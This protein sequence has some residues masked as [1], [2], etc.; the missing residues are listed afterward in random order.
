MAD[1]KVV[2]KKKPG[3]KAG[4]RK[5]APKKAV[6]KKKPGKKPA[7]KKLTRAV[8]SNVIVPKIIL[9][10]WD[11]MFLDAASSYGGL[12]NA[13]THLDRAWTLGA[14]FL[15]HI[16]TTPL[17][18]STASLTVKQHMAGDLHRGLA[19]TERNLFERMRNV[20]EYLISRG[21]T[22]IHTCIDASP[23]LPED[24]LLAI[25]IISELKEEFKSRVTI[26]FGPNPIFGFK[27]DRWETF[28]EA[29]KLADF[30]SALPEKSE[31][32]VNNLSDRDGR[33]GFMQH[34]SR[35][36]RLA[37]DLKKPIQFHVDQANDPTERGAE[38]LIESL[39][40]LEYDVLE[41]FL[42]GEPKVWAVHV[43]SPSAYPE[44]RFKTLLLNLKRLNV[45]VIV[46][47]SA[48]VSM[49][50][51]RP[52]LTPTHNSIAR[53]LEMILA[54]IPIRLGSDNI[55]DVF[56]P[57]GDGDMLTESKIGAHAVR[58]HNPHLWAKLAAGT[59]LTSVDLDGVSEGLFRDREAF[60]GIAP[61]WQ[62]SIK[63]P[64]AA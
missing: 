27:D 21:T 56:V 11:A 25:R 7:A 30:L 12:F 60:K 5:P 19:Y 34:L 63:E 1:K 46:C 16:Q 8:K 35:V 2:T 55:G 59:R 51:L 22:T 31:V 41:Y 40:M 50:Q 4:K 28:V 29:A 33:I 44:D 53:M 14:E 13:H 48:A 38:R 6:A 58:S 64:L 23:D 49:R 36:L 47:P 24:G 32:D 3:K 17:D 57:E 45:G 20:I 39:D 61:D 26:F 15:D 62:A 52:I 37:A 43:I 10:P 18:A 9:P 54:G 42:E